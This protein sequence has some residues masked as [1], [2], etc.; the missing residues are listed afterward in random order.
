MNIIIWLARGGLCPLGPPLKTATVSC[1]QKLFYGDFC[2]LTC[3]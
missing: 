2:V 1:A 3:A